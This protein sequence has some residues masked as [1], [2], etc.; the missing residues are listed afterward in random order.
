MKN[1]A[2]TGEFRGV[3]Q[4]KTGERILANR[5]NTL[6]GVLGALALARLTVRPSRRVSEVDLKKIIT[7]FGKQA[8]VKGVGGTISVKAPE[9]QAKTT[10]T[11]SLTVKLPEKNY[12]DFVDYDFMMADKQMAGFIRNAVAYVNEAGIVDRYAKMFET[13]GKADNV[14]V[15]ADGVTT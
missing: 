2:K 13:N 3:G 10:D 12:A 7:D 14:S 11:F 9:E 15:I 1:L 6:E 8:G 5:G 4:S